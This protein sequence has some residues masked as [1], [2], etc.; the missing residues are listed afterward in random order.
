VSLS[1]NLI[2]GYN[3]DLQDS[4]KPLFESLE[5]VEGSIKATNILINN[6]FPKKN[7]LEKSLTPEV[8]ATHKTLELVKKGES[9]RKAHQ[10]VRNEALNP[11]IENI[12]QVLKKSIHI[13]GTGNLG[14]DNLLIR[15]K[16]EKE[17]L[18]AENT[19]FTSIIKILLSE[20]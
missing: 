20:N 2:S 18:K 14:L 5:I 13:G 7:A 10:K 6:L 19:A 16:E 17:E 3:R 12:G 1:S 11:E 9:F 4:K 15:L 8:F